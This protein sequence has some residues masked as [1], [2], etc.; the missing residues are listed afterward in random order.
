MPD[1]GEEGNV[2]LNALDE[3][4]PVMRICRRQVPQPWHD[5]QSFEALDANV[6][7]KLLYGSDRVMKVDARKAKDSIGIS[8]RVLGNFGIGEDW[9]SRTVPRS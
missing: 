2:K 6:M 1:L 8:T 4:R 9:T 5:T 3:E 7:I